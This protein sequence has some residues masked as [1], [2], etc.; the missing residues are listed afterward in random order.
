MVLDYKQREL[1]NLE[2][3]SDLYTFRF[4]IFRGR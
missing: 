2:R 4:T 1:K 3:F